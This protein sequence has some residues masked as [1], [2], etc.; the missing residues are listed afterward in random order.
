MKLKKINV[1]IMTAV[2]CALVAC[3]DDV[4]NEP[5]NLNGPRKTIIID[6]VEQSLSSAAINDVDQVWLNISSRDLFSGPDN[7]KTTFIMNK[8]GS[9]SISIV[10]CA[11]D[12]DNDPTSNVGGFNFDG[13]QYNS[14]Q[15]TPIKIMEDSGLVAP[16]QSQ[17]KSNITSI[18]Y[19]SRIAGVGGKRVGYCY[20][21]IYLPSL[22][23][24]MYVKFTMTRDLFSTNSSVFQSV[25][26]PYN[27]LAKVV[28]P[29]KPSW[30]APVINSVVPVGT[31][32]GLATQAWRSFYGNVP[33]KVLEKLEDNTLAE[34][35]NTVA[36]AQDSVYEALKEKFR[37]C[38]VNGVF[39]RAKS[40]QL[41]DQLKAV[42][43]QQGGPKI[44]FKKSNLSKDEFAKN[45]EEFDHFELRK[46]DDVEGLKYV[47]VN[48]DGNV[49]GKVRAFNSTSNDCWMEASSK[50]S[51]YSEVNPNLLRALRSKNIEDLNGILS[52]YEKRIEFQVEFQNEYSS[53]GFT[54]EEEAKN[55]FASLSNTSEY[56][57]WMQQ[58]ATAADGKGFSVVETR[59]SEIIEDTSTRVISGSGEVKTS[60]SVMEEVGEKVAE[61]SFL[62][63][64]AE[65]V[66]V[67]LGFE[68]LTWFGI[69]PA[70]SMLFGEKVGNFSTALVYGTLSVPSAQEVGLWNTRYPYNQIQDVTELVGN[71]YN[72][73]SNTLTLKPKSDS[74]YLDKSFMYQISL[75]AYTTPFDRKTKVHGH[76]PYDT[77]VTDDNTDTNGN[78][79]FMMSFKPISANNTDH[80]DLTAD[81]TKVLVANGQYS[82]LMPNYT[83]AP[84]V[85]ST[86]ISN[87]TGSLT[88]ALMGS[89]LQSV[90]Q[91]PGLKLEKISDKIE[92]LF[93]QS[94]QVINLA[95]SIPDSGNNNGHGYSLKYVS[96]DVAQESQPFVDYQIVRSSNI[97]DKKVQLGSSVIF[98]AFDNPLPYK[99]NSTTNL[100]L[101][102]SNGSGG[103]STGK[104]YVGDNVGYSTSIPVYLNYSL[105]AEP[106]SLEAISHSRFTFIIANVSNKDYESIQI[107]GLP[108]GARIIS[109]NPTAA[110]K[111]REQREIKV[112]LANM[113]DDMGNYTVTVKGIKSGVSEGKDIQNLP[114][115]VKLSD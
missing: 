105:L 41:Y 79:V 95:L 49:V 54:S 50:F 3:N 45:V 66:G 111:A 47:P 37:A 26:R 106:M 17:D 40:D 85:V 4:G 64:A 88:S 44:P 112:D 110:L 7:G 93:L 67:D 35:F 27:E 13:M 86:S 31:V 84:D 36:D 2:S 76:D 18:K 12:E 30:F 14:S 74:D 108:D 99:L 19:D 89:K 77:D 102:I 96:N 1:L 60:T 48:K 101:A 51:R 70:L 57:S 22:D 39:D 115:L 32:G 46:A 38:K 6:G 42:E 56:R 11:A 104:L 21:K 69:Q 98:A 15:A 20:Y 10:G 65:I 5:N 8:S 94:N 80:R 68:A 92:G 109:P 33:E 43:M 71:V 9:E 34:Y 55:A 16:I 75:D 113:D 28:Q 81:L 61:R 87:Y 100:K 29:S 25:D 97:F 62:K 59:A 78:S 107:D 83:S 103:R 72:T 73:Y 82:G 52:D 114:L 24:T 90:S 63:G 53:F 23:Q 91:Y 58:A